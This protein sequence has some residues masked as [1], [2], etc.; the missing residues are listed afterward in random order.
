MNHFD[1]LRAGRSARAATLIVPAVLLII[2]TSGVVAKPA[3]GLEAA[4]R[5]RAE[6][7]LREREF[8]LEA[9]RASEFERMGGIERIEAARA[10]VESSVPTSLSRL[11]LQNIL[12]L[13]ARSKH[14]Q[15]QTIEIGNPI[16]TAFAVLDDRIVATQANLRGSGALADVVAFVEG[17]QALDLAAAVA[18][19]KVSRM[20]ATDPRYEFRITLS[21]HHRDALRASGGEERTGGQ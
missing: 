5:Q 16:D 17:V 8:A 3:L 7:E 4:R 1:N 18:E 6:A 11:D 19:F 20:T 14:V 2:G 10:A 21:F 13:V 15:V 9:Q 12:V